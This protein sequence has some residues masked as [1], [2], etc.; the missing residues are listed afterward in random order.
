MALEVR[1]EHT[2][3]KCWNQRKQHSS[4]ALGK[5]FRR[6]D[7]KDGRAQNLKSDRQPYKHLV[8]S[9]HGIIPQ[10]RNSGPTLLYPELCN[11]ESR[12]TPKLSCENPLY[13]CPGSTPASC[14]STP[15][16]GGTFGSR[17]SAGRPCSDSFLAGRCSFDPCSQGG[18]EGALRVQRRRRRISR[19][20]GHGVEDF[21]RQVGYLSFI[22]LGFGASGLEAF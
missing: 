12:R 7:R 11:T 9:A 2:P 8:H 4:N 19:P 5:G 1:L 17:H 3:S 13:T 22:G 18:F 20:C 15:A 14:T 21:C 10:A 6:L 16:L